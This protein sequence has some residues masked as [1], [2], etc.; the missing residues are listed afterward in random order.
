FVSLN[1]VSCASAGNCTAVGRY[2]DGYYYE[3]LLLT[4]TSGAWGMGVEAT[5]PSQSRSGSPGGHLVSDG[6]NSVSCASAG[7]CSAV[8]NYYDSSSHTEGVLLTESSDT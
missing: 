4:E 5:L 6:L 3:G 8:G 7:N 1:S 2:N